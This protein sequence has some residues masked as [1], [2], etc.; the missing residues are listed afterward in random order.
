[1]LFTSDQQ[2][3][4]PV[5]FFCRFLRVQRAA[6]GPTPVL[7]FGTEGIAEPTTAPNEVSIGDQGQAATS[8]LGTEEVLRQYRMPLALLAPASLR[9]TLAGRPG[10]GARNVTFR[11]APAAHPINPTVP[12]PHRPDVGPG[13]VAISADSP[14]FARPSDPSTLVKLTGQGD[15]STPAAL[16]NLVILFHSA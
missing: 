4:R 5:E 16:R 15:A 3:A 14:P 10:P 12:D 8:S 1:M 11:S 9:V 7:A 6:G 13:D 2:G